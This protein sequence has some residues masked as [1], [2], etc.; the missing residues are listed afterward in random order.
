MNCAVRFAGQ[1]L[2]ILALAFGVQSA[3]GQTLIN[4]EDV[5]SGT[6]L[7][8]QYGS[9]GVHFSGATVWATPV[10]NSGKNALYS[11]PPNIEAFSWPGPLVITFDTGQSQVQ[12]R[13]GTDW[14][15]SVTATLTAFDAAGH[16]VA[17]DGPRALAASEIKTLMQV[18]T[19]QQVIRRVELLYASD[20]NEMIDDL[21]FVGPP[22][23]DVPKDPPTI[24]ITD[25]EPATRVTTNTT[26]V[27]EGRVEGPGVGTSATLKVHIPRPP[28]S[29]TT[30]DFNHD[31][32]LT[33]LGTSKTTHTFSQSITLSGI[34]PQTITVDA[35]NSAGLH[36][37]A[38]IVVD[39]MPAA[40]RARFQAE[41]G[42]GAFGNFAF[43]SVNNVGPCLYA[44]YANGSV[45][46]VGQKTFVVRAPG[47]KKWLALQDAGK[48]PQLGCPTAE[49]HPVAY[50]GTAQDFTAGRIYSGAPGTFFVPPVFAGA[51]DV[52]GD[53]SGTGLPIADPTSDSRPAFVTWLFQQFRR[54]G[55][56]LASTLE[57]RGN[58]PKLVVERQA[59]DGS[60]FQGVLR[61]TNPTIVQ[62]FDCTQ[63]SGPCSVAAPPDEP[64][65][66][67]TASFCHNKQFDWAQLL[68]GATFWTPDPPEWV[69]IVGQYAQTPVWGALF[70]VHLATGDN[71][72][73][74]HSRFDPCPTPTLEAL[75]NET[76]CPSDWDLKVRPLPGFRSLQAEG[77]DAVQIEFERVDVQAHLVAYGDPTPGDLVFVSGRYIV[78]CG[79]GPKFKT[80]IHPPSIYTSVHSVTYNNRPATEADIWVNRFFAGGTAASDAVDF[81]IYPPPRPSP[82]A[83][84]GAS[85]PGNQSGAV[86]VTFTPMNPFG[87]VR[88][89]VTA[90]PG[91]PEVTKFGEMKMRTDDTAF[92]F[93]G[94]LRVYWNCPGGAC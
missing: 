29:S 46:L 93:D 49:A 86:S 57:I 2:P 52:L 4:F 87:P 53:E 23:T 67:D 7:T 15:Q 33:Q 9:K 3:V 92:G 32:T 61:P 76:I 94:R 22:P 66:S 37:H 36:G 18:K 21:Q 89:H 85:T 6:V 84:L 75:V 63:T 45:A 58:P 80:E 51:I 8:N 13:A 73:A 20:A 38:S 71:P 70:D 60:L 17:H 47:F 11:V 54:D 34:G 82:Q 81:D 1:F 56:P 62:S 30:A 72:F 14:A 55:I 78:D 27:V 31:V 88:V 50:N 26:V 48:F 39:S 44:V 79:H 68:K 43:G 74:H 91:K 40:I 10:A 35:E 77:R 83:L 59:G 65:R 42:T 90:T 12:L 64:L 5:S 19:P 16:A 24:V 28:S 41:G 69:P 25:P